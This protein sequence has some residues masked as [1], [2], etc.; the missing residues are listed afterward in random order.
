MSKK[1]RVSI[2]NGYKRFTGKARKGGFWKNFGAALFGLLV[3]SIF[4]V[5]SI[6]F[7][8][9]QVL[10]P[11]RLKVKEER[12]GRYALKQYQGY[13]NDYADK[14]LSDTTGSIYLSTEVKL[15]NKNQSREKFVKT[16]LG[17]V[18]YEPLKV[19]SL[20]KYGSVYLDSASGRTVKDYSLVNYGEEVEFSYID[21]KKI[22]FDAKEINDL[23]EKAEIKQSDADFVDKVTDLFA[24]YISDNAKDLPIKTVKRKV[25]LLQSGEGYRVTEREDAYLDELLFSSKEFRNALDRFSFLALQGSEIES[26]EH[27]DW[28][29]KPK[30]EQEKYTEPYKW[31]KFRYIRYDWVG[32]ASLTKELKVEPKDYVLPTGDGSKENPAGLNTPVITVVVKKGENGEDVQTPI[33]V[34]LLQ[35]SY[36]SGAIKEIMKA[37]VRNRGLDPKSDNK[38]IYTKWKVENLVD[39]TVELESNSALVDS[40]GN[41]S[42]RTGTMYGLMDLATLERYQYVEL[43]D[44]YASTELQ[45]KYLVWGRDFKKQVKPVWFKALKGTDEK[46]KIPSDPIQTE[47]ISSVK[48]EEGKEE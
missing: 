27:K 35:V 1:N 13:L 25:E 39:G 26:K 21:Y 8:R 29:A 5:G 32:F 34:T 11:S 31:E 2:P 24:Q 36:G 9:S 44:W 4:L 42:A 47:D 14:A 18:K 48:N 23:M 37:N 40:E 7:Y 19:D 41:V 16:V 46:V 38:Y 10:Y 45:E 15:Q 33:R 43:Q 12:T 3:S 30:E 17:T 6:A 20:N 28:S 22:K